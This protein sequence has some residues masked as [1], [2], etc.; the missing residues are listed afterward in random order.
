MKYEI[1]C[2]FTPTG[3]TYTFRDVEVICDNETVL[4]FQYA[5]MSDGKWKTATFPKNTICGW[6]VTPLQDT[7]P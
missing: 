3:R 5:A 4:Q 7:A 6:S 1:L 2:I